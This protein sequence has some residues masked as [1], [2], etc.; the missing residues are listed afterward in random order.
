MCYD[1]STEQSI[2]FPARKTKTLDIFFTNAPLSVLSAIWTVV[3]YTKEEASL[4]ELKSAL[5]PIH[6]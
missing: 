2:H 3:L 5:I 6:T 4:T 1:L